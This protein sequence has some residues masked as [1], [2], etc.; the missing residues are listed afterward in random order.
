VKTWGHFTRSTEPEYESSAGPV[1]CP[2]PQAAIGS[3]NLQWNPMRR[4]FRAGDRVRVL[5]VPAG[6]MSKCPEESRVAFRLALGKTF[7]VQGANDIGWLELDLGA[8]ADELLG[9]SGNTIW[10]EPDCVEAAAESP[11]SG[12]PVTLEND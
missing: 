9:A 12:N 6:V 4:E 5:R 1:A 10:I 7:N 2:R 8:E 3:R 11:D